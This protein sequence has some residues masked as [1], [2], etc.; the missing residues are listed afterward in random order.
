[1]KAIIPA[2]GLGTRFLPGTKSQPKEMLQVLDKPV[3]QY[4]V[5]EALGAEADEV[6]IV[7]N[8][9]KVTIEEHFSPDPALVDHLRATGKDEYAD[10]VQAAGDLPVS[11]VY[12]DEP[13]GLGHAVHC[14]A[15]KTGDEPFYVLLGDVI[16][17]DSSM[18]AR[19][20]QVHRE[21]DGA[22]VIAVFRVPYEMVSRFG[23]IA[24]EPVSGSDDVWKISGMV[25]KP[26]Q[27]Q[28]PS[29]LAI[30][31]RYLL[32]PRVMELLAEER[33]GAG[34]EI[35]LTDAMAQLLDEEEMY[36]VIVD[37]D[38]GFDTGTVDTW[39]D[40]NIRLGLRDPRFAGKLRALIDS[41]K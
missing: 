6:I 13:R 29:N 31:G 36:A 25:E 30:F 37:E 27:D 38:A 24:G 35:Q 2:A 39:L 4:V 18:L 3:I 7:N 21:H 16:V 14:G 12:Q 40:T 20:L 32:T 41:L 19:M 33:I 9:S 26:P 11:Y 23:V 1:M 10:A 22:S 34:G 17:P 28:A 15:E 5:E 8:R